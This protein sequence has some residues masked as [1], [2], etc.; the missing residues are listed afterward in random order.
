[1]ALNEKQKRF[2]E[3][4]AR[5]RN[6][7]KSYREAYQMDGV[8]AGTC[9]WSLLKK[10]EIKAAIAEYEQKNRVEDAEIIQEMKEDLLEM[11]RN[12]TS[13]T[14]KL[15]TAEILAKMTGA[16]SDTRRLEMNGK[17]NV[18]IEGEAIKWAN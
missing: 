15:K 17:I 3:I 4:Y 10:P 5:T 7:S 11:F 14:H 1:M 13:K 2:A 9:G 18:E 8:S 12:E 6:A 16:F